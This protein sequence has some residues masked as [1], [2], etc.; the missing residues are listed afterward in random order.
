[1]ENKKELRF[2]SLRH[3]STASFVEVYWLLLQTTIKTLPEF[4]L[5]NESIT[6]T[7]PMLYFFKSSWCNCWTNILDSVELLLFKIW[8]GAIKIRP[9]TEKNVH[10]NRKNTKWKRKYKKIITKS[11]DIFLSL[12]FNQS[13][14]WIVF[15][16][17]VKPIYNNP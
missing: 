12:D 9:I 7:V 13:Y 5:S 15:Q 4:A 6:E 1:M 10:K 16:Y 11:S 8:T 2:I 14:T 3:Y 17:F